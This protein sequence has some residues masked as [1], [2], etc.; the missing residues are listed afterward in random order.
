MPGFVRRGD[1]IEVLIGDDERRLLSLAL[2]ILEDV[3]GV[4]DPAAGR[5][6]YS[7]HP[8]DPDAD[9]RYRDLTAG[10]L[11]DARQEDR[12]EL[13]ASLRE[14]QISSGQAEA[15]MRVVGEARL[16]LGA[17]AGLDE[18]GWEERLSSRDEPPPAE[19]IL[20]DLLGRIQDGLV[21]ALMD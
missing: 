3:G 17:R 20:V 12:A 18:D 9:R 6:D 1:H 2:R 16:A 7:A 14:S 15:W 21:A 19:V 4:D 13:A 5:L 10:M 8:D 11:D